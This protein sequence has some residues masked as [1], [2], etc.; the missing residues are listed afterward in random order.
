M[1]HIRFL[2]ALLATLLLLT[3]C[4][5]RHVR[6]VE[7]SGD[8]FRNTKTDSVYQVLPNSYEPVSRGEEY[9]R[10]DLNGVEFILHEI[11]GLDTDK[12]LCSVWGDV[13]CDQALDIPT[14]VDW[15]VSALHVCT[16]TSLVVDTLTVK[17]SVYPTEQCEAL[18]EI[19][20]DC[21]RYGEPTDYPS[22][23]EVARVYTLR[24]ETPDLP[25]IY[26]SVK[27]IEYTE[28]IVSDTGS[29]GYTFLYDRAAD[30]CVP[31]NNVVFRMLDG[32]ALSDILSEVAPDHE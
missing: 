4:G 3:A 25:G 29:L 23:A 9:G 18:F 10:L 16:N 1:K 19:L 6:I 26:Y 17:P 13:Y 30:H 32:E 28:P 31:V 24:F 20:Q 2:S 12:W 15:D 21:Y 8:T 7:T 14:F 27:L 5:A 11:P 22:W